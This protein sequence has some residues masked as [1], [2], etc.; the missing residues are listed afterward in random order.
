MATLHA[1]TM[2]PSKL[3]LI[4]QW[5]PHQD[6]YQNTGAE[7][8]LSKVGGFRL[9][10][11]A[12]EVGIECMV[13][14]D[15]S[16][17]TPVVYNIPL[18]YRG[19]PRATAD[20]ALI[21]TS[22]HGVLGTRWIYDGAQD[23]VVQEQILAF[24][25]GE[26]FA[27]AQGVSDTRDASVARQASLDDIHKEDVSVRTHRVLASPTADSSNETSPQPPLGYVEASWSLIEGKE[28]RGVFFSAG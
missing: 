20:D 15:L 22:E 1:T 8:R 17:P 19:A 10:D 11:P 9:D 2:N 4:A 16:G 14:A 27:Q 6:W 21:G 25:R 3:E 12:G 26:V 28:S 13:V 24:M 23:P 5:L 7:P 18:S